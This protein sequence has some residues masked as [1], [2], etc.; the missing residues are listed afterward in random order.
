MSLNVVQRVKHDHSGRHRHLVL[1]RLPAFTVAAKYFQNC[2]CHLQ[3]PVVFSALS[4]AGTL[5]IRSK[6]LL[7]LVRHFGRG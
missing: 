5:L 4:V 7:Q 2:V 1:D 6:N 3:S